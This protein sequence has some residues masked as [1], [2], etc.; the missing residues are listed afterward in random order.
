MIDL[1]NDMQRLLER[2]AKIV[3]Q[4]KK[5]LALSHIDADGITSMAIVIRMLERLGKEHRWR[6]VHQINSESILE[7]KDLVEEVMPDLVIFSDFGSG[8]ISLIEEYLMNL[9]YVKRIIILDHHIPPNERA[10]INDT[11]TD[12]IIEINPCQHRISGSRELSGA[13]VSFLFALMVSPENADLSELAIVGATGDLQDYYGK[14]FSGLNSTILE[15]G[16]QENFISV[17]KDL[18]LFGINTRPLPQLLQYATDPYLPGLTGD[19][20]ACYRFFNELGIELKDRT[21]EWR[22]WVDLNQDEKQK[23]V[24]QLIGEL[25]QF[26][27]D[28]RVAT[29][30]IGDVITLLLRPPRSEVSTAKE[31]S[32]LLNACGRNR[33]SDVGVKICLGDEESFQDG[34]A[35]LQQHRANLA[36]AIRRI[37]EGGFQE[38][39]GIYVVNDPLTKDTII[40]IVIGMAQGSTIIPGDKPVLGISTNTTDDS[41]LVKISGRA[42][43]QIVKRGVNLKDVFTT[44]AESMNEKHGRLAVEAGGHPM[45]AGA[46]VDQEFLEEFVKR[47]SESIAQILQ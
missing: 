16:I 25:L 33:R 37:E 11:E 8:Q 46:F 20:D 15:I 10:T 34:I 41:P 23:V 24:Q 38:M 6:N 35:L 18:T 22:R 40:G 2:G 27:D 12:K 42:R 4:S 32:T 31:F 1:P 3:R 21:D 5:V 30:I 17:D 9:E 7:V 36:M 47:V 14:G 29:G 44:I 26:Y 45:A 19:Q 28:P 39:D 13:G 43:N